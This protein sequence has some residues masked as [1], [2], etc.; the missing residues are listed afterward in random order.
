MD[1]KHYPLES[2]QRAGARAARDKGHDIIVGPG[3]HW[4]RESGFVFVTT[5]RNCD[6]ELVV[7]RNGPEDSWLYGGE[8]TTLNCPV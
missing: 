3:T 2:A 8:A 4:R 6:A 5:C 1:E 7:E